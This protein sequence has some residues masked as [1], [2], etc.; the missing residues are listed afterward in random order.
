MEDTPSQ[1]LTGQMGRQ[2]LYSDLVLGDG[3]TTQKPS[4]L[5]LCVWGGG[6]KSQVSPHTHSVL[7]WESSSVTRNRRPS[8]WGEGMWQSNSRALSRVRSFLFYVDW[9]L[10]TSGLKVGIQGGGR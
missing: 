8:L 1:A 3:G 10:P 2:L 4:L 7:V 5:L 9:L 6:Q